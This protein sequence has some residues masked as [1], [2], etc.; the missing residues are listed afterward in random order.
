M[1]DY[2]VNFCT[3]HEQKSNPKP[4]ES[5]ISLQYNKVKEAMTNSF[6]DDNLDLIKK[7]GTANG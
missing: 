6:K 5:A 2:E 1:S 3:D 7:G 4:I